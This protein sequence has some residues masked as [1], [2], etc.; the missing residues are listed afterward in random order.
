MTDIQSLLLLAGLLFVLGLIA[1]SL[2]MEKDLPDHLRAKP[3]DDK[4]FETPL[5]ASAVPA[6]S[7]VEHASATEAPAN[8]VPNSLAA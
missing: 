3:D 6:K 5:S 7:V 1:T 4:H 2:Y 8:P